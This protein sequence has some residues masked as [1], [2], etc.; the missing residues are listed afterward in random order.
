MYNFFL[1]KNFFYIENKSLD[2]YKKV[3]HLSII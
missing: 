1:N 2:K 3:K